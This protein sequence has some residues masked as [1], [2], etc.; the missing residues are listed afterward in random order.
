MRI[1]VFFIVLLSMGVSLSV[2]SQAQSSCKSSVKASATHNGIKVNVSGA[3][4]FSGKLIRY[5][6]VNEILV[7]EFSGSSTKS[8]VFENLPPDKS[9]IVKVT[10]HNEQDFLCRNKVSEFID[11]KGGK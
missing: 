8:F 6:G 2:V 1:S 10:F 9:Y 3:G 7:R 5:D 4:E 11:L